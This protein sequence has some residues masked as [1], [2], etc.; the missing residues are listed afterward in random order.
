MD[1][2]AHA[3]SL[4]TGIYA[5]V[6]EGD[7]DPVVLVRAALAGGVRIVQYRAKAGIHDARAHTIRELTR[8]SDAL[9]ILNDAWERVAEFDADGVHVGPDDIALDQLQRIRQ[10]IGPRLIGVSCGTPQEARIA[11]RTGADYAGVGSIYATPSKA[12]AGAPIG[13]TG[14]RAVAGATSLPLAAIGGI[15]LAHIGE[16][17]ATGVAMA[18]VISAITCAADPQ[19]ASGALVRAWNGS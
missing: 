5:I 13:I 11:E 10:T 14:L 1:L 19:A 9:F 2:R 15:T 3:A 4:L 16:V 6:N 8:R 7:T 17:R 12:D 18:A